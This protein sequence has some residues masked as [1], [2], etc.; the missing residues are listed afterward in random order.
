MPTGDVPPVLHRLLESGER[1]PDPA[2]TQTTVWVTMRDGVRLATE[3]YSPP[4]LPAPVALVR[5]PYV[6]QARAQAYLELVRRGYV[7]VAQ[8]C[9]GTGDSEPDFWDF[10][11]YE[12]E[13]GHDLVEWISRQDW[14]DGFIGSFGGS[15]EAW[16]QYSHA[17]HP[18]MS[19]IVPQVGG[20]AAGLPHTRPSL[21]MFVNAYGRTIGKGE[22][23]DAE[24]S[25]DVIL[26]LAAVERAM[27]SETLA[28]GFFNEPLHPVLPDALLQEHPT[29]H[30]LSPAERQTY[31]HDHYRRLPPAERAAFLKLALGESIFTFPMFERLSDLFGRQEQSYS[32]LFPYTRDPDFYSRFHAPALVIM[33]WYDW[34]LDLALTAF[35]KLS[36]DAPKDVR[37]RSRLLI[38]PDAHNMPGYKEGREHARYGSMYRGPGIVDVH[39]YWYDSVRADRLDEWPTVTY[40]LMGANEWRTAT[41]WPPPEA[42]PVALYLNGDGTLARDEPPLGGEPNRYVYDPE[43]PTPTVGGS[44]VSAVYTPGS[45]DVSEVQSRP[46]VLTYTTA[47]LEEDLDVV[48]TVRVRLFASSTAR[49]TDFHARLSDV[50]PDGRAIQLQSGVLRARYRDPAEA[51]LLEPG[52][53]YELEIFVGSTGNRFKQGHCVRIDISSADFPKHDRNSNRGGEPGPPIPAE[54]TI[55]CDAQRPSRVI[56]PVLA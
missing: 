46:D 9:R 12:T 54:Q 13:D 30:S 22:N 32:Y 56:L 53:V 26:D 39:A 42:E 7:V 17:F 5:T 8:D 2:I 28:G 50:F 35:E 21:Y 45:C 1:Y 34:A 19:T 31:L 25:A 16:T 36:R 6:R 4:K 23:V 15:Y 38:T 3:I 27:L 40:H 43:D 18:A 37:T 51:R 49:D 11:V 47:P 14:C 41:A 29:L 24:Q 44:I 20:H 48:G 10:A 55:Y 52:T 33:G